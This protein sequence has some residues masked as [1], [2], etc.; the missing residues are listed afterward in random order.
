MIPSLNQNESQGRL[1]NL[2][3]MPAVELEL[4]LKR[5][6][7]LI[8][9]KSFLDNLPDKGS[10]IISLIA[11]IQHVLHEKESVDDTTELFENLALKA[12]SSSRSRNNQ[13]ESGMLGALVNKNQQEI[14]VIDE[15]KSDRNSDK[16]YV[17]IYDKIIKRAEENQPKKDKYFA[18]RTVNHSEL[19]NELVSSL[20]ETPRRNKSTNKSSKI[21]K[22]QPLPESSC[23]TH[24]ENLVSAPSD[25]S[26][27]TGSGTVLTAA[28]SSGQSR[29]LKYHYDECLEGPTPTNSRTKVVSLEES[30]QLQLKQRRQHE[31]LQALQTAQRLA[32]QL[33]MPVPRAEEFNPEIASAKIYR[34]PAADES[35][36]DSDDE[37]EEDYPE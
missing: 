26:M 19:D 31:E 9:N 8:N 17:N 25:T 7:A 29:R 35:L 34:Q 6:K 15:F 24:K 10:K 3:E 32:G 1:G 2:Q 11:R 14:T 21:M 4:L 37:Q 33:R 23:S 12:E 27:E 5:Q 18:H 20:K 22:L 30:V 36:S 13:D 16:N 28:P